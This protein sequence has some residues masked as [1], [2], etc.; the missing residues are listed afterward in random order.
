[1]TRSKNRTRDRI[2]ISFD[3]ERGTHGTVTS[4]PSW[5]ARLFGRRPRVARVFWSTVSLHWCFVDCFPVDDDLELII[6]DQLRWRTINKLPF[7][8]ARPTTR[9]P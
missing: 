2:T 1:M 9:S 6:K 8:K 3:D 5:L 7:A 4:T